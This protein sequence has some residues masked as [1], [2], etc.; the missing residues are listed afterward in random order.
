[1]PPPFGTKDRMEELR[2]WREE[3]A[4]RRRERRA[5]SAVQ[6]PR[7]SP[8]PSPLTTSPAP[9]RTRDANASAPYRRRRPVEPWVPPVTRRARREETRRGF[10][11]WPEPE[12][13]SPV[14]PEWDDPRGSR[15]KRGLY[16][17]LVLHFVVVPALVFAPAL[18]IGS[19]V[20]PPAQKDRTF[21]VINLASLPPVKGDGGRGLR[22]TQTAPKREVET[23]KRPEA[24]KKTPEPPKSPPKTTPKKAA[25]TADP[26]ESR[27]VPVA[28]KVT[29]S[30]TAADKPPVTT[31]ALPA[32]RQDVVEGPL[33]AGKGPVPGSEASIGGVDGVDFPYNYYLELIRSKI[34]GAWRVP[35]GTVTPGRR[36]EAQV[37][38]RIL[39]DGTVTQQMVEIPSG[40]PDYD[41]AA[42]RA[43]LD[44]RPYP[45][46]P[47]AFGGEFLTIHFQ[48]TYQAK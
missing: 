16:A 6:N 29:K 20:D 46:L 22:Q 8:S 33:I 19:F 39:R 27:P 36:A 18:D 31:P 14:H 11:L 13:I 48:F 10:R 25:P 9:R 7:L 12:R 42:L 47:P 2:R 44:G 41:Q 17:S 28:E 21:A 15:M 24:P 23:P 30:T 37:R 43:V 32:I 1:V 45:P 5:G 38:F 4:A 40:R 3:R 35:E 26:K 34:A